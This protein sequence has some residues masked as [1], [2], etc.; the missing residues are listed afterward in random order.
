MQE[1][2]KYLFHTNKGFT[3]L[4][5]VAG[6]ALVLGLQ[7][8]CYL[9]CQ[10]LYHYYKLKQLDT[11]CRLLLEDLSAMQAG[12]FY[13]AGI[14]QISTLNVANQ[15]DGYSISNVAASKQV[16]FSALGL[17]DFQVIGPRTLRF[18][19]GGSPENA[20]VL[21][22]MS[23]TDNSLHK[24]LHIQPVTGRVVVKDG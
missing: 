8:M 16:R 15:G 14:R 17:G 21:H 22:I 2:L 13:A 6:L 11:A 18:L 5:L 4:E 20:G 10:Q 24:E 12:A 9:P 1:K 7:A 3:L 23:R 19:P